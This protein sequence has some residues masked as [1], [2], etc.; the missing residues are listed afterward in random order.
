MLRFSRAFGGEA[1]AF[2]WE[3]EA[4]TIDA[5]VEQAR[6]L[7]ERVQAWFPQW[8]PPPFD[9]ALY[10]EILGIP[11]IHASLGPEQDAIYVPPAGAG[12]GDRPDGGD[13]ESRRDGA[14][15]RDSAARRASII[16]NDEVRSAGRRNFSLA[17]EISHSMF[18]DD[19]GHRFYLRTRERAA[20]TDDPEMRLL[21]RLCDAGAAELLMPQPSFLHAVERRGLSASGLVTVAR[22]FAVSLAAAARRLVETWPRPCTALLVEGEGGPGSMRVAWV[23]RG[24]RRS[25]SRAAFLGFS[26]KP[27]AEVP[28]SSPVRL[29]AEDGR[30]A[31]WMIGPSSSVESSAL[32]ASAG[33]RTGS[34]L[35]VSA[36][37]LR[38]RSPRSAAARALVLCE[39][40]N[41]G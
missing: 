11:V 24:G 33:E 41:P 31:E 10:A 37:G 34:S 20:Y 7:T 36:C 4:E 18:E 12:S 19:G 17:H 28:S 15:G 30:E 5:V 2:P 40:R 3:T 25:V 29:V 23:F 9:P 14:A 21:E 38:S 1:V 39:S 32:A 26:L 8:N 16:L 13:R 35:R 22:E 27:G 6:G